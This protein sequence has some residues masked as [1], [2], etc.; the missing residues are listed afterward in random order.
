MLEDFFDDPLEH[1]LMKSNKFTKH[2]SALIKPVKKL[3]THK[4]II[5]LS[6]PKKSKDIT[7]KAEVVVKAPTENI[8]KRLENDK[9]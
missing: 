3:T 4:D 9:K 1:P 7:S 5:D 6:G 8:M 2:K